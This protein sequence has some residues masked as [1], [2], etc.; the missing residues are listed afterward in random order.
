MVTLGFAKE[1]Q[2]FSVLE[3][4]AEAAKAAGSR[5]EFLRPEL[6]WAGLESAFASA[7][8]SLTA[9]KSHLSSTVAAP[10]ARRAAGG[11]GSRRSLAPIQE[12]QKESADSQHVDGWAVYAEGVSRWEYRPES[13][14]G[15]ERPHPWIDVKDFVSPLADGIAIRKL[16]FGEGAERLVFK[17]QVHTSAYIGVHKR[18]SWW[19]G[20]V[21][22]LYKYGEGGSRGYAKCMR[23]LP[24]VCISGCTHASYVCSVRMCIQPGHLS[25]W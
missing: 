24:I 16:P 25:G 18:R 19:N 21:G 15:I 11:G 23:S 2:D 10:P 6:S 9:T 13:L 12:A 5:G 20:T 3:S 14:H 1:D 4:M 8:S 22:V 7:I 17:M